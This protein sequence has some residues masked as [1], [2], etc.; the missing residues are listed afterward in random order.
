MPIEL[1]TDIPSPV[2]INGATVAS[3]VH[4]L[5][6]ALVEASDLQHASKV[7]EDRDEQFDFLQACDTFNLWRI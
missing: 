6:R 3:T 1:Q 2:V 4:D 7:I 5:A